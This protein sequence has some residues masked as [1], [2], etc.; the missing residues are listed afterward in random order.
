M[1]K[2]I[3]SVS[4]LVIISLSILFGYRYLFAEKKVSCV[5]E[6]KKGE[7]VKD[8]AKQVEQKTPFSSTPL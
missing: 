2:K 3:I 7:S 1:M 5:I 8:I 4:I 6:I